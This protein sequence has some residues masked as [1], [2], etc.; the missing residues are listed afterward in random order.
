MWALMR[1]EP[2]APAAAGQIPLCAS[3]ITGNDWAYVKECLDSGWVS[4]AGPYV[5]RFERELA[6]YVGTKFAIATNAGTAAL[7][8]SLLVSGVQPDDE[9]IVSDMTFI[10]PVNAI[11]YVGAWPVLIDAEP[12][13][14]QMDVQRLSDFLARDC[15]SS[16]G[17]LRNRRSGRRVTT[18]MP[19][20][21][22]GH[23]C[24]L[25]PMRELAAKYGLLFI[26]DSTE[27]L[28]ATYKGTKIGAGGLS[29]LSFN[30]NKLITTG[31]GGAIVTD[32][33]DLAAR[34][35][36]LVTQAKDDPLEY[37]HHAV[38]FN[39]RMPSLSAALGCSQLERIE[40]HL[41]AKRRIVSRYVAG[42]SGVPGISLMPRASWAS[43][44]WWLYTVRIDK[45]GYGHSSR[46]LMRLLAREGIHCRPVFQPMHESKAHAGCQ[47]VGGE[48]AAGIVATALSLPSSVG[49]TEEDQ[50][51]VIATIKEFGP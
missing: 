22:L 17:H 48:V 38:G 19:V 1:F 4:T 9:V 30:G 45:R 26:E 32:D 6:Q 36:Y 5:G 8:I 27:S 25:D 40:K 20:H 47:A 42:L 43:P 16:N 33:P 37:V 21:L 24:D 2:E 11:R 7:H 46:E 49:L 15:T 41:D 14:W 44:A 51:R 35:M 31:G 39:Y 34:A 10:A 29:S 23:P 3:E 18:L 13:Y 28:G 12:D 50:D